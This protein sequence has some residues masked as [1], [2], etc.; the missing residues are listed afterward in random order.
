MDKRLLKPGWAGLLG[1]NEAAYIQSA[2]QKNGTLRRLWGFDKSVHMSGIA[3]RAYPEDPRGAV[4][5]LGDQTS[6]EK[7]PPKQPSKTKASR[8]GHKRGVGALRRSGSKLRSAPARL[9]KAEK[10]ARPKASKVVKRKVKP[11]PRKQRVSSKRR[12]GKS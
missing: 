4:K 5:H 9:R 8:D 11:A 7:K 12:V 1:L 3:R 2:L 10:K 6:D